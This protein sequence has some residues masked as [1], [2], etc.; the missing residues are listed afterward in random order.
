MCS[1]DN[2][3]HLRRL[4]E[5]Q[6]HLKGENEHL[7]YIIGNKKKIEKQIFSLQKEISKNSINTFINNCPEDIICFITTFISP[8]F[9]AN[10]YNTN[11]SF[12]KRIQ[13]IYLII[14]FKFKY[15][16]N[17]NY[18]KVK[19]IPEFLKFTCVFPIQYMRIH[20]IHINYILANFINFYNLEPHKNKLHFK[21]NYINISEYLNILKLHKIIN[22][23]KNSLKNIRDKKYITFL[24]NYDIK[25]IYKDINDKIDNF[26]NICKNR[27]QNYSTTH[28]F[29]FSYIYMKVFLSEYIPS[30]RPYNFRKIHIEN[31]IYKNNLYQCMFCFM[32]EK[33]IDSI[34]VLN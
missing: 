34:Y 24:N 7:K 15:N 8:Y 30:I 3:P 1:I 25:Y 18:K 5:L 28:K 16:T 9:I 26:L 31:N 11:K 12:R 20:N 10:L 17:K 22:K 4:K 23:T 21:N 19:Y 32:Y 27:Q 2:I 33:I 6:Q 29:Y 13:N 14:V